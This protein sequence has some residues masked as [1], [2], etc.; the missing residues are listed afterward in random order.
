MYEY[1]PAP[2]RSD[3]GEYSSEDRALGKLRDY[4][5]LDGET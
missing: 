5:N 4:R 3:P 1:A 2:A